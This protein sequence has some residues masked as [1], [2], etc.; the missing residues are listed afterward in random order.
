MKKLTLQEVIDLAAGVADTGRFLRPDVY[1]W[2]RMLK[3]SGMTEDFDVDR[4]FDL[5]Y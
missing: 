3:A 1:T 2:L 4:V 5:L